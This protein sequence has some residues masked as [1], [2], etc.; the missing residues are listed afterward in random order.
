MVDDG[1][2]VRNAQ[3][4]K[5]AS[6]LFNVTVLPAVAALVRLRPGEMAGEPVNG[7][8][9]VCHPLGARGQ[10]RP[11]NSRFSGSS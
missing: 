3:I 8:R 9:H 10:E 11:D 4:L 5:S 2:F 1:G 7:T 6:P